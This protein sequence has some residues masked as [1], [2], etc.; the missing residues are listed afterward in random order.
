MPILRA[1][2]DHLDA[3]VPLFDG[4]RCFYEQSSDK[5]RARAFLADRLQ[6]EDSVIL[7]AVSGSSGGNPGSVDTSYAPA[8]GFTQLYPLF[9]SVGTQRIWLLNDLFVAPHARRR[10]VAR[11][12]M[13]A[14]VDF[15]R[16]DGAKAVDLATKKGNSGAK[17][18]YES[19]GFRLDREFD[20]YSFAL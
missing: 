12:L 2:L 7:L 11:D 16:E 1:T 13:E 18:L 15:G 6:A 17:A 5:E 14:A 4:Y 20:H 19:L 10:G 3:L 9:T 8:D